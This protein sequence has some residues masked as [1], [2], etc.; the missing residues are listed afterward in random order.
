[1]VDLFIESLVWCNWGVYSSTFPSNSSH[2]ILKTCPLNGQQSSLLLRILSKLP[3][4]RRS[5]V[6][7]TS[8]ILW[9]V[10]KAGNSTISILYESRHSWSWSVSLNNT[11]PPGK[12]CLRSQRSAAPDP[13]LP[14]VWYWPWPILSSSFPTSELMKWQLWRLHCFHFHGRFVLVAKPTALAA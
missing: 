12:R 6:C 10:S 2:R 5:S 9:S 3:W 8:N 13:A 4:Q 7:Q 11:V 14:A 1:M